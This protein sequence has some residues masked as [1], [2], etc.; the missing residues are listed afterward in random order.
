MLFSP[1]L[2][3]EIVE[4]VSFLLVCC[5]KII[6]YLFDMQHLKGYPLVISI[7]FSR[8]RGF[9]LALVLLPASLSQLLTHF[10][11]KVPTR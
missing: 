10:V 2:S 9:C 6:I 3:F 11:H 5:F 7:Q 4:G 8:G 1:P